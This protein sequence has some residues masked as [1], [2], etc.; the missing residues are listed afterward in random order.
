MKTSST[1]SFIVLALLLLVACSKK[2]DPAAAAPSIVGTWRYD[3]S[4]S[5]NCN[6]TSNDGSKTCVAPTCAITYVISLTDITYTGTDTGYYKIEIDGN[7]ITLD[8]GNSCIETGTFVVTATSLT[9]TTFSPTS[10][11]G[12]NS[13]SNYTRL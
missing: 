5:S 1:V 9:I 11:S 8:D 13:V 3:S 6:D 4:V 2:D 10:C 12:C 7:S